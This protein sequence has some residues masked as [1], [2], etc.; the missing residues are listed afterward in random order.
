MSDIPDE[1]VEKLPET[2]HDVVVEMLARIE[3]VLGQISGKEHVS[4]VATYRERLNQS[5]ADMRELSAVITKAA[6][7][8]VRIVKRLE[9]PWERL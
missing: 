6:E 1:L 3:A 4:L 5:L 2:D 9:A 8:S 7:I